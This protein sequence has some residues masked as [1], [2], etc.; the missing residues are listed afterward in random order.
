MPLNCRYRFH[1][2]KQ[3]YEISADFYFIRVTQHTDKMI[4]VLRESVSAL[5]A[6]DAKSQR[7]AQ[8]GA[9]KGNIVVHKLGSDD[10]RFFEAVVE[11]V[12]ESI[13]QF[14]EEY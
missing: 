13:K 6:R 9:K 12:S 4:S 1:N 5:W 11:S 8:H 3:Q 10:N 14:M 7:R 2:A